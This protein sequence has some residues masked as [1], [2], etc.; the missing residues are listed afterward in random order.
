VV[1][2]G[3]VFFALLFAAA[4]TALLAW[5]VGCARPSG[6]ASDP[7]PPPSRADGSGGP[8]PAPA[9]APAPRRVAD[10]TEPGGRAAEPAA[11][12]AGA[13]PKVLSM[14]EAV[15][16]A[17]RAGKGTVTKAE[18]RDRPDVYFKFELLG[19]DGQKQRVE[20]NADGSVR[21]ERKDKKDD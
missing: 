20:L 9:L 17:E 10:R 16:A 2:L 14:A 15:A 19:H 1:T 12:P 11:V 21:V 18:R 4:V 3:R 5:P 6:P 13:P 8:P 7:G